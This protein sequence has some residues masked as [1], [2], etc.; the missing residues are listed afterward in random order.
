MDRIRLGARSQNWKTVHPAKVGKLISA[1]TLA[2]WA[3]RVPA[4]MG[5][6]LAEP[7]SDYG[8]LSMTWSESRGMF[9]GALTKEGLQAGLILAELHL[10]LSSRQ[11]GEERDLPLEGKTLAESIE[12]V[13]E[14]AGSLS[15]QPVPVVTDI[16][17]RELPDHPVGTGDP[18]RVENPLELKELAKWF[19][20]ASRI[21][22][23]VQ[24]ETEG[25]TP[26]RVWPHHFDMATLVALD[27]ATTDPKKA[28]SVTLGMSPGDSSYDEPYFYMTVWPKPE[29]A[30]LP[31][32]DGRGGWHTE[33]WIGGV[34]P[35]TLLMESGDEQARQVEAF[36]RSALDAGRVILG[37]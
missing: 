3:V 17:R 10:S 36:L 27:P 22:G 23:T 32:L 8:H 13:L 7:E 4:L 1:R 31:E 29:Y 21:L 35:S 12:W 6:H 19:A 5:K 11:T 25:A 15:R 26:V 2:H 9:L 34:L 24:S 14:N 20:N 33:G 18:F 30:D 16:D 28:R 37:A